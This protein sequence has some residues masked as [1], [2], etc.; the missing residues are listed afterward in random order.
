MKPSVRNQKDRIPLSIVPEPPA[1]GAVGAT[2]Y[3]AVAPL[4]DLPAGTATSIDV[5]GQVVAI[6]N[7]D[8]TVYAIDDWD[9]DNGS[10]IAAGRLDGTIV[11]ST[12]GRLRYDVTSGEVVGVPGLSV[13]VYQVRVVDGI[14]MIATFGPHQVLG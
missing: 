2:E 7:I 10:S 13:G 4:A 6:F 12:N 9:L 8:G 11:T 3:V 14:I 1:A 5:A